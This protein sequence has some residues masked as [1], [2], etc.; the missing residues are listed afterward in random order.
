M[1]LQVLGPWWLNS[2]S[3]NMATTN[4]H[5]NGGGMLGLH[6]TLPLLLLPQLFSQLFQHQ[7][8]MDIKACG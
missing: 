4:Q 2:N 6:K 7:F 3:I 5:Q 8:I 1:H